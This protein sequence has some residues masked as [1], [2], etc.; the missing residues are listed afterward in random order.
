MEYLL[1]S[2]MTILCLIIIRIFVIRIKTNIVIPVVRYNQSNIFEIVKPFI[3]IRDLAKPRQITQTS[4]HYDS[5]TL[6]VILLDGRA[7]WIK[8]NVFYEAEE[9]NGI[10][11]KESAKPVD[12]MAMDKVQ[13][14]KM[15]FIVETLTKGARDENWNSGK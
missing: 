7:Y 14:D 10:I 9:N 11:D 6:S 4:K 8:D 15:V 3:M 1:G 2:A 13:L 12:I 5:Q